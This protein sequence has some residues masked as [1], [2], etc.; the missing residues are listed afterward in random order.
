MG[1]KNKKV[2]A[3]I[4]EEHKKSIKITAL[5]FFFGVLPAGW[6]TYNHF[7]P[8]VDTQYLNGT[9]ESMQQGQSLVGTEYNHFF[10]R[11]D[12]NKLIKI[13]VRRDRGISYRE[14][15]EVEIKKVVRKSGKV[16]YTFEGYAQ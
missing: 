12:N 15:A 7:S 5:V 8:I 16:I 6:A 9:L 13:A 1:T 4:W 3:H 10:I 2:N 11:L 14:L